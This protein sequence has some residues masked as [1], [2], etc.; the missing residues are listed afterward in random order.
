MLS[1]FVNKPFFTLIVITIQLYYR[2]TT[3]VQM[4]F[5]NLSLSLETFMQDRN[6]F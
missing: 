6:V 3:F 4:C 1:I 5:N 2:Y